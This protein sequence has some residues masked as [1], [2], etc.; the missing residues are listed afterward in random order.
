MSAT[1][2]PSTLEILA[3][4]RELAPIELALIFSEW[5][6]ALRT[7]L[8]NGLN[9]GWLPGTTTNGPTLRLFRD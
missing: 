1:V 3:V 2:D 6:A 8:D 4:T 7:A 5:L 9:A